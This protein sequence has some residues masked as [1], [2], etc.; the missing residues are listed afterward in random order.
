M[1]AA[2]V[3]VVRGMA[4]DA[5]QLLG[6]SGEEWACAELVRRG[7]AI[8]ARRYRSRYGEIDIV[9]RDEETVVFVEVKARSGP[10]FGGGG[11][12]VTG[13]KQRRIAQMAVDYLARHGLHERPCRFD[14]VV[15]DVSPAGAPDVT[16]HRGAFDAPF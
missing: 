8:V 5:R 13:W 9:A 14:V 3:L 10:A 16:L 6:K 2:V 7:Y 11:E 4:D 12:A 15:V 1:L